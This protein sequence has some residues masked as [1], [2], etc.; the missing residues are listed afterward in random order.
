MVVEVGKEEVVEEEVEKVE[1]RSKT[2]VSAW[3]AAR[4]NW[5][6]SAVFIS[7]SC[8]DSICTRKRR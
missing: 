3:L 8:I 2:E 4:A 6:A 5:L 7:A 1:E